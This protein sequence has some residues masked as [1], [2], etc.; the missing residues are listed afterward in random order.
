LIKKNRDLLNTNHFQYSIVYYLLFNSLV[1]LT[2][3]FSILAV[4]GFQK[5]LK[6]FVLYYCMNP[7][8]Y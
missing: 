8:F 7:R 4:Y 1:F 3:F 5:I 6:I 2:S